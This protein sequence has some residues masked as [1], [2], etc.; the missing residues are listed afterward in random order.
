MYPCYKSIKHSFNFFSLRNKIFNDKISYYL[1]NPNFLKLRKRFS[2]PL[3]CQREKA[4][5]NATEKN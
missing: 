2:T 4:Y 3:K 5:S 1:K